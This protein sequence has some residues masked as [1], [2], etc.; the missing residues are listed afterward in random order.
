VLVGL[1]STFFSNFYSK[2]TLGDEAAISL[3]RRDFTLL[4]RWPETDEQMGK[5]NRKGSTYQVIEELKQNDGVVLT[6][7]PRVSQG[8]APVSRMGAARLLENYPLIINATVT[9]DLYLARW[10][11]FAIY[12]SIVAGASAAAI[13]IAFALLVKALGRRE[14]DI[15]LAEKLKGEAEAASRAKS[16]FLSMMSHEIRTPLTSIIGFA[17]LLD[18][19][20]SSEVRLDASHVILRN[21]RHL[22][23]IIN[24][25]LDISKIEAGRL[26][27]ERVPFSP[28]DVINGLDVMMGPQAHNKGI[29]FGVNYEYPLPS[30]VM[31][32]PTRWKQILFNL[33]SNAIKFTELGTVQLTLWY[34]RADSRLVCNVV[35]T[36]IGISQEQIDLLF[37]PFTQADSAIS[38]RFG[39][40]GLGLHLVQKLAERMDG[41]VSVVSEPGR[42]SVFE[43]GIAAPLAPDAQ[44]LSE[45]PA[46]P[47][48]AAPAPSVA[49][50]RGR[51]LLAEDGPD[52]QKLLTAYF[53]RLG[54]D[55]T[56]VDNGAQAVEQALAGDFDIVLMDMQMP[57]MDGAT[58][59]GVLRAAG[60]AGPIIALT[61]N[62]MAD[63][64]QRYLTAGCSH[65]VGKPI[66][67]G[68]LTEIL[69][70][71]L[72]HQAGLA[73]LQSADQLEE[74]DAIRQAFTAALPARFD[75]MRQAITGR[76]WDELGRLAHSMKGSAGS[77]GLPGV[78]DCAREL[79]HA[80][81]HGDMALAL[82]IL[83]QMTLRAQLPAANITA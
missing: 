73:P 79:E 15:E 76:D 52:N 19:A 69:A 40:S 55:F 50:L 38:R 67:F 71:L 49:S 18:S 78:T 2:I 39:G 33:C 17:E 14:R 42:G 3:Y 64:V 81:L 77:F 16:E 29:T 56:I 68:L 5:I 24:D 11:Q 80:A 61:A 74:F 59:T 51:I 1:S 34:D 83:Q 36:G 22:L 53:H 57:V 10:R 35:D 70:G 47:A 41:N 20:S 37:K 46:A 23:S 54:L 12:I 48:P 13:A 8:G 28:L 7:S 66:D 9:D 75:A 44:W 27:L 4:A 31:G 72:D 45:A 65:C 62:V 6:S 82:T 43:V 21:G 63:D 60:F 32:D 30:H 25:I 58:A 26:Q